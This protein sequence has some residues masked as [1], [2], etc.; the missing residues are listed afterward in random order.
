MTFTQ[1]QY[2]RRMVR[3]REGERGKEEEDECVS[4]KKMRSTHFVRT[5]NFNQTKRE[6]NAFKFYVTLNF[7]YTQAILVIRLLS[8]SIQYT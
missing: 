5:E 8:L 2:K 4:R 1:F 3:E 6:K 7:Q